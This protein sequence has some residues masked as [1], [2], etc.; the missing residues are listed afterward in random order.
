[1][2]TT[3]AASFQ[4]GLKLGLRA[5]RRQFA[6]LV[7]INGFV[8]AMVGLE[9]SSVPLIATVDFGL[10]SKTAVL[11]FLIS[12]GVAKALANLMAGRLS[13]RVGRKPILVTGWLVGLPVPLLIILAPS[14]TCWASTKGCAGR[15]PLS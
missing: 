13:D 5:N 9:R 4:S 11:S 12:F 1:M 10:A 15:P 7:A 6:L 14:W 2:I 3:Q 8:G